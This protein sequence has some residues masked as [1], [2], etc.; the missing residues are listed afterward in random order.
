MFYKVNLSPISEV[1]KLILALFRR[2]RRGS[3]FCD[4]LFAIRVRADTGGHLLPAE[5]DLRDPS[6]EVVIIDKVAENLYLLLNVGFR[7]INMS[8]LICAMVGLSRTSF[9]T[10]GNCHDSS[11]SL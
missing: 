10:P 11:Y 2:P 4:D 8:L 7:I 9:S 6:S 3:G 5:A 1:G